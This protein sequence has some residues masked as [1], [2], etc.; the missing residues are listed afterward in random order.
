ML[1]PELEAAL[2]PIIHDVIASGGLLLDVRE[3]EPHFWRSPVPGYLYATAWAP[4]GSGTGI[5]VPAGWPRPAQIAELAEQ[6]RE[7]AIEARWRAEMSATWPEC[8]THPNSHPLEPALVSERAVWLCPK[9]GE[10]IAEIGT[11]KGEEDEDDLSAEEYESLTGVSKAEYE[12]ALLEAAR[13]VFPG[14]AL[15][16]DVQSFALDQAESMLVVVFTAHH[17]PGRLFGWRV[18]IWPAPH[19]SDRMT[20]TVDGLAV[21]LSVHL[22]ELIND[23][24]HAVRLSTDETGVEWVDPTW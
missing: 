24:P 6:L 12:A 16:G 2:S 20:G 4:D 10:A 8:P 18:P 7:I 22:M 14:P 11:L 17:L 21:V 23:L 9:S 13:R 19:P 5:S 1:D 15:E 3:S